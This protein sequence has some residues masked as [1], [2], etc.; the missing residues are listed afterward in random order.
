MFIIYDTTTYITIT[1][2][3]RKLLNQGFL[4]VKLKSS[5][6]KVRSPPFLGWSLRSICV[7]NNHGYVPFVVTIWSVPHPRLITRF[8]ALVPHVKE[9]YQCHKFHGF[10]KSVW[11]PWYIHLIRHRRFDHW[12]FL[13][14]EKIYVCTSY[15]MG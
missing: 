11:H 1:W 13:S 2:F 12:I 10:Q 7:T 15:I 3:T 4:V 6:W 9:A 14:F 5:P 8:V